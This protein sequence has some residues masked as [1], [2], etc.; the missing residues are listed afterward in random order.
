MRFLET[1]L[2]GVLIVEPAVPGRPC[3]GSLRACGSTWPLTV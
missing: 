2:D 3:M 1:E